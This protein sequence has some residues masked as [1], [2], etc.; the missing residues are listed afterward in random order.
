MKSVGCILLIGISFLATA[1]NSS[2]YPGH[3]DLAVQAYNETAPAILVKEITTPYETD[4]EKVTAIFRWITDNITYNTRGF[5]RKK[6]GSANYYEEPDDTGK[7]LKPLNQRVAETVLQR[8]RAVCDGYARLFKTLCDHA[9][10]PSEIIMGYARTNGNSRRTKFGSNH[11]WNAVY[12]DSNWH[13][14]DV[15]WASGFTNYKGDEFIRAYDNKYFLSPPGQFIADHYPEDIEWTLLKDPP[16][17]GE[18]NYA[19]FKYSGFIKSGV[20]SYL[21]AKGIIAASLGD[22]IRFEVETSN[23]FGLLAVSS[24]P[25]VDTIWS[26]DE[27]VIIGGREKSYTYYITDPA[28]EWLYVTCNGRIILRYKL[29]IR[30]PDDKIAMLSTN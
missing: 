11:T 4:R 1:Q 19:P 14:L 9:G 8:R 21:P 26:D 18:F 22:S 10:V 15:T 23:V 5:I 28:S 30:K 16:A 20:N 27:P 12:I 6:N 17:L 7:V 29:N 25:P 13:L 3:I 24:T 2:L